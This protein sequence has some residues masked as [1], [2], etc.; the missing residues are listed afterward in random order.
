VKWQKQYVAL[1]TLT[2]EEREGGQERLNLYQKRQPYRQ[3]PDG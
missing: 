3:K 1:K 2:T